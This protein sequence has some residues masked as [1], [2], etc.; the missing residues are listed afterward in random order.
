MIDMTL[1]VY[2][3]GLTNPTCRQSLLDAEWIT[4]TKDGRAV[5]Q[6]LFFDI[7]IDVDKKDV[8]GLPFY[9]RD[10]SAETRYNNVKRWITT[11]E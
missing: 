9:N 2:K 10:A 8:T 3:T 4:Q 7:Y 5:S 6:H 11:W 1:N